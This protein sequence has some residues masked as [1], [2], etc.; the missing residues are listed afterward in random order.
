MSYSIL[1]CPIKLWKQQTVEVDDKNRKISLQQ[2]FHSANGLTLGYCADYGVSPEMRIGN[3]CMLLILQLLG[4]QQN[5]VMR[6][7]LKI[8]ALSV[9]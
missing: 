2:N 5:S 7:I 6:F 3:H 4:Y 9:R 8:F 1:G